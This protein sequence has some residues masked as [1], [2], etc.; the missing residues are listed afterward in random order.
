MSFLEKK[1]TGVRRGGGLIP[2]VAN[3]SPASYKNDAGARMPFQKRKLFT[4]FDGWR[5]HGVVV[6]AD[7][8]QE[9]RFTPKT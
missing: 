6:I 1:L 8:T 4:F 9:K 7:K 3:R 2:I 5:K